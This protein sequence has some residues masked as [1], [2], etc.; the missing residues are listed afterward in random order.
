MPLLLNHHL[1]LLL[2]THH[3]LHQAMANLG[4]THTSTGGDPIW[5]PALPAAPYSHPE[6]VANQLYEPSIPGQ[7]IVSEITASSMRLTWA[8]PLSASTGSGAPPATIQYYRIYQQEYQWTINHKDHSSTGGSTPSD[9]TK[10]SL[11]YEEVTYSSDHPHKNDQDVT[12]LISFPGARNITITFHALTDLEY[13]HDWIQF[14]EYT[15]N[16]MHPPSSMDGNNRKDLPSEKYSGR[17]SSLD[18]SHVSTSHSFDSVVYPWPGVGAQ[19]SKPL[20]IQGDRCLFRFFTDSSVGSGNGTNPNS[21]WGYS[22]VAKGSYLIQ[23]PSFIGAFVPVASHQQL[24]GSKDFPGKYT[25]QVVN[26]LKRA[27]S[28]R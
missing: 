28:Y 20:V 4:D 10:D 3:H 26:N 11:R 15:K 12:Q 16:P 23:S 25:T 13:E 8:P 7:P 2:L 9:L 5:T 17:A 24:S 21:R 22:F 14:L 19:G 27:T 18:P 6:N 1:L